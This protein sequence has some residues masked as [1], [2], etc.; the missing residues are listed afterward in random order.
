MI[1]NPF[2]CLDPDLPD[3]QTSSTRIMIFSQY[4]DSVTEITEILNRH[5]PLVRV[6]SFIGQSSAGKATKGFT[7]KEQLKVKRVIFKKMAWKYWSL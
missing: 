7:Q 6:M 3:G 2:S 4:R 1:V 5:Q